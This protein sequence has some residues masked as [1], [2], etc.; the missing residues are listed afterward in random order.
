[1]LKWLRRGSTPISGTALYRALTDT[2]IEIRTSPP[3]D[4]VRDGS[5][6]TALA[7]Q[8]AD[9]GFADESELGWSLTWSGVYSALAHP[10]YSDDIGLLGLPPVG[11][12]VPKLRSHGSL[13]D[14]DFAISIDGWVTANGERLDR[15]SVS[16]AVLSLPSHMELM[17]GTTW[18]LFDLLSEFR[19]RST[20]QRNELA[21]RRWWGRIRAAAISAGARLDT[22]LFQT[23][24]LTP[25]KLDVDFR[26]AEAGGIQV[27][28][29]LPG[30]KN[31]PKDWLQSFDRQSSIPDRYDI[32]TLD[33]IVQVVISPEVKTVLAEIKKMPGRRIAGSR[34]EAF[35]KNPFATIG[36]DA[37]LVIDAEQFEV[38]RMQAGLQFDA[39]IAYIERAPD[40]FPEIVGID[41]ESYG[42]AELTDAR[43]RKLFS[44]IEDLELFIE[45]CQTSIQQS[46]QLCFWEGYEFE[47]TGDTQIQVD[48][49]R[50]ALEDRKK[51]RLIIKYDRV[52]DLSS[53]SSRVIDIGAEKP[54]YSPYIAKKNEQDGWW[55]E[56]LAPV[57]SWIPEGSVEPIIL[58]A[59]DSVLAELAKRIAHAE[60]N[61][62]KEIELAGTPMPMPVSE[63]KSIL[64]AFDTA[65]KHAE[66]GALRPDEDRKSARVDQPV[67][68]IKPNIQQ[69]DHSELRRSVLLASPAEA[70][71]PSGLKQGVSLMAHQLEGVGWLQHLYSLAPND[72]RGAVL[73]DDMG[74]G[75]TLQLLTFILS[76][77]DRD[78]ET[79]PA[80]VVAPLSLLEN[81]REEVERFFAEGRLPILTAYGSTL[82]QLRVSKSEID[83]QLKARGLVKF[84]RPGWR[85]QSRIVLTTYETLRDLEFS[86]A[87]EEWSV[88]ICD[89]AQKIK[90]PN[91]M[92]TRAAKKQKVK[93]RVACT[94]TP[95]ENSLADLWCLFDFVQPGLLG[96]LD[97]FG[98]QYRHPIEAESEEEKECVERLREVIR[99][100]ILRRTKAEV[101]IDLKSKIEVQD[102]KSL[103][104]SPLQRSLYTQA[105]N[106]FQRRHEEASPSPFKNH[107]TLLQYL[108]QVC[109]DP[110]HYGTAVPAFETLPIYR[111]KAPKLDWLL[112]TL[113]QIKDVDEKAII[114]CEFREMQ[115]MLRSFIEQAFGVAPDIINGDTGVGSK[116]DSRQGRIRAF[117]GR[118]GFGVIIL[119][120]VAVG[121]G[122]N[123][124]AAN[125]VIHY[126]RT[127]NPAKEDQA[128]DRAY[129]IGQ[130]KDVY[131]YCPVVV[132]DDFKTFDV[133]LDELL[134]WKRG[135]ATDMLNGAG[136]VAPGD[137]SIDEVSPPATVGA[138]SPL[139]DESILARLEPKYFEAMI[140][141][142]W[143]KLGYPQVMLTPASGDDGVDV[144]AIKGAEGVLIQC[145]SSSIHGTEI[146][147]EAV[148]DVV[149]GEAAYCKRHPTVSFKKL[150]ATNQVFGA[151][152]KKHAELNNVELNGRD[153]ILALL[154]SFPI[155]LS[156]VEALLY[157]K[158]SDA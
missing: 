63:A 47:I 30:F 137:F 13:I 102:C 146:G 101:A 20:E 128:T 142:L 25:E 68:I 28:E 71:L 126:T 110:R 123:I 115:R 41:I 32:S 90:N 44:S 77:F 122:V 144:V 22:F 31:C 100:Q 156:D 130:K 19:E 141:V 54:Y 69:V 125:H 151:N 43:E 121:F 108:R 62:R 124:Q 81:W 26:K 66:R 52:Y 99:P 37:V 87:T 3:G 89:E 107:L 18:Q 46:N 118:P 39:F 79:A 127:W 42:Q 105:V 136:D 49:L 91:A 55:P 148:K 23:I 12:A 74:L 36:E 59:T 140:A 4:R 104:M 97:D 109:T 29:I 114:F 6:I 17:P 67:L 70:D 7:V 21:N 80:L 2:G 129:R 120:P 65:R 57:I 138:E 149:A 73:A 82:G 8:L 48:L 61:G 84:L 27:I 134:S 88:M 96:A 143:Q 53:Y 106:Q 24:V 113:N 86:F 103:Q 150:C 153:V 132:A 60:A 56:N 152:A 131:V 98:K 139:I 1:M 72:C 75:K 5:S 64:N 111:A 133:R 34:A 78:P 10:A 45:T 40:D 119:S 155:L 85:G 76:I 15:P 154:S 58:P 83:D 158:W 16:G 145:K 93:F 14:P 11:S 95:V 51:P 112:R 35:L 116:S 157:T 94:G 50:S 9:D 135:I 38:A 117:Q 147:W 33:G 92:V